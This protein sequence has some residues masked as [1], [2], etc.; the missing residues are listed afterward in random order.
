MGLLD[1]I[2]GRS[3]RDDPAGRVVVLAEKSGVAATL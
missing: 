1:S 2:V 3:F